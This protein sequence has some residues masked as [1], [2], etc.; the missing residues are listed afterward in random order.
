[1]REDDEL[2]MH[3]IEDYDGKESKQKRNTI[4]L[5]IIAGLIIGSVIVYFKSGE[6]YNDYVG[7]KDN[8]GIVLVHK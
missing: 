5:V 6:N 2:S 8:P 7:T 4:K 1:M 3:K